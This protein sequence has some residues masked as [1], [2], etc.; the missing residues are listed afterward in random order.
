MHVLYLS[1]TALVSGGER[2]L[3]ELLRTPPPGVEP[4]VLC[5][6]GALA[7]EVRRVVSRSWRSRGTD[8][9]LRLHRSSHPRAWS[10]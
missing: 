10:N 5:P 7:R 9:S 3:L 1:H 6:P 8:A 2:A 4:T